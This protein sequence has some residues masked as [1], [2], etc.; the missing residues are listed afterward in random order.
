[1]RVIFLSYI[2]FLCSDLIAAGNWGIEYNYDQPYLNFIPLNR[3][4]QSAPIYLPRYRASIMQR[5]LG[6]SGA[7]FN[8]QREN[9]IYGLNRNRNNEYSSDSFDTGIFYT[10]EDNLIEIGNTSNDYP[11]WYSDKLQKEQRKMQY[12]RFGKNSFFRDR[13][14]IMFK[15]S[16]DDSLSKSI[17]FKLV[18][19]SIDARP[20]LKI[21]YDMVTYPGAFKGKTNYFLSTS[22]FFGF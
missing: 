9:Y 19:K 1:M 17:E 18:D 16:T 10:F 14:D 15:F 20:E 11:I 7:R 5:V 6:D 8:I 3:K 13:M 12:F 4:N 22:V 21:R 2:F